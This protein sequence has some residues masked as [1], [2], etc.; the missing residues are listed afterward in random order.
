MFIT[1]AKYCW[2]IHINDIRIQKYSDYNELN[3]VYGAKSV[4]LRA[5]I[6]HC[7]LHGI[8]KRLVVTLQNFELLKNIE[9]EIP[10]QLVCI[11]DSSTV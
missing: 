10:K 7:E 6:E 8:T 11:V 5:S 4:A 9:V 3:F 2:N 1:N